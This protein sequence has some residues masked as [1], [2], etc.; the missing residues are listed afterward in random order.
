MNLSYASTILD[1]DAGQGLFVCY[2]ITI[3][4]LVL[5]IATQAAIRIHK[6]HQDLKKPDP[7]DYDIS[8]EFPPQDTADAERGCCFP[9]KGTCFG[10]CNKCAACWKPVGYGI[11]K[12]GYWFRL[13]LVW[14]F[15]C[16]ASCPV[17]HPKFDWAVHCISFFL[18]IAL[19][20]FVT[21]G[22][23]VGSMKRNNNVTWFD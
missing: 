5:F 20:L 21:L 1:S 13:M 6:W 9:R 12:V 11:G 16:C 23:A 4:I 18:E 3:I 14:L 22:T 8:N 7:D 15:C 10:Y 2:V 17:W 19:V